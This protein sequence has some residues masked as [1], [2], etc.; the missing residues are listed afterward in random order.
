[1]PQ[2][3]D[4]G[5]LLALHDHTHAG[6]GGLDDLQ[7]A[8][9][10]AHG[11]EVLLRGGRGGDLTLGHQKDAAV[12]LHGIVQRVNGDLTLYIKAQC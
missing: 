8:A 7:N 1:M 2:A 4:P 6:L 11:I 3:M 5:T 9:D 10:R 12:A